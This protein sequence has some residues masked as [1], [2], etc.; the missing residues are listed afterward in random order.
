MD[1]LID[2]RAKQLKDDRPP[3]DR[4]RGQDA[5]RDA[6]TR[7]AWAE[8]HRAQAQR[9]RATLADLIAHHE[10]AADRLEGGG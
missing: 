7:Q 2:R 6:R 9:H 1:T 5:T 4:L 8:W 3:P 10:A